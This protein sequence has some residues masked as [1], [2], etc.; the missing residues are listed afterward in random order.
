MTT[1]ADNKPTPGM[2]SANPRIPGEADAQ[3]TFTQH[4]AAESAPRPSTAAQRDIARER[5]QPDIDRA[6][7][8]GTEAGQA[9][10]RRVKANLIAWINGLEQR[11][12]EFQAA[13]FTKWLIDSGERPDPAV[14][15]LRGAGALF[16]RLVKNEAIEVVGA[17]TNAGSPG[18][19]YNATMRVVYRRRRELWLRDLGLTLADAD[20]AGLTGRWRGVFGGRAQ[21]VDRPFFPDTA[22][23]HD[24][25]PYAE[26]AA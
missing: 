8:P 5:A 19:N 18:S 6:A 4:R 13:D 2:S 24:F 16:R 26:G 7:D 11:P 3:R 22:Q 15:D 23:R 25:T 9:A 14:F 1:K 17:R 20:A 10:L 12:P 21:R